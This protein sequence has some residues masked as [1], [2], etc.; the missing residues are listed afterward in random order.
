M[1]VAAEA[2][3]V[4]FYGEIGGVVGVETVATAAADFAVKEAY[5]FGVCGRVI[6][7]AYPA[8]G[9]SG[10]WHADGVVRH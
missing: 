3:A 10:V 7:L 9:D 8:S 6:E 1:A 4:L 5:L 2:A